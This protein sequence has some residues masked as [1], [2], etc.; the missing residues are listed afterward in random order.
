MLALC[1]RKKVVACEP[2]VRE[3]MAHA[4]AI[5]DGPQ[6]GLEECLG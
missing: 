1:S 3:L 4:D 5:D 6:A 2:E